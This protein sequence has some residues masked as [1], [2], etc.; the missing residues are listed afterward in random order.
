M[1]S[2]WS[3]KK[4]TVAISLLAVIF[5]LWMFVPGCECGR[6]TGDI[7]GTV[8]DALTGTAVAGATVSA[9]AAEGSGSATTADDGTYTIKDLE[10]SDNYTVKASKSGYVDKSVSGVKVKKGEVT[11]DVNFALSETPTEGAISGTV[12]G[13][14]GAAVSDVLVEASQGGTT[15]GSAT[16]GSDGKYTIDALEAGTYDVDATPS[17]LGL[18]AGHQSGVVVVA[19]QV[20]T[21][22]DF[23][24]GA[25]V[26]TIAGTVT[27]ASGAPVGGALVKASKAGTVV[28]SQTSGASGSYIISNL[29][30]GTYDV[31]AAKGEASSTQTGKVVQENQTTTVDFV[32]GGGFSGTVESDTGVPLAGA[33]VTAS[34]GG[35]VKGSA[36]VAT[37]GTYVILLLAAGSYD[38]DASMLGYYS[39]QQTGVAVTAGAITSN[40]DLTLEFGGHISGTVTDSGGTALAG[41]QVSAVGTAGSGSDST[42]AD[43]T[44]LI[45]GV[46]SG[47]YDVVAQ[48]TGY[49]TGQELGVVVVGGAATTDIDFALVRTG[50]ISGTVTETG[51]GS[52]VVGATVFATD[53][54]GDGLGSA[55]TGA[56][57]AYQI[58]G[59]APSTDYTVT[60]DAGAQGYATDSQSGVAVV[61]GADTPNVDFALQN[62][63]T[64]SGVVTESDGTTPIAGATVSADDKVG[65]GFGEATTAADGTYIILGLLPSVNYEVT[66]D[67]DNFMSATL[68]N[69]AVNVGADTPN[70]NFA[71]QELGSISG[72]VTDADTSAAVAG[73]DVTAMTGG[74]VM[75]T[76]VTETDGTYT[77]AGLTPSTNYNVSAVKDGYSPDA[78]SGVVVVADAT[79]TGI[80]FALSL[81]GSI[82][83]T[84]TELDGTTAIAGATVS[85]A[86]PG[87]AGRQVT[88][89]GTGNYSVDRL[90]ASANYSVRV[91]KT[92]YA[93][94]V[95]DGVTVVV[96]QDTD[97][98]VSL[99]PVAQTGSI[100]GKVTAADGVT[101]IAGATVTALRGG[102]SVSATT[103]ADG[104]YTIAGLAPATDYTV[105]ASA[106]GFYPDW[107]SNVGVTAGAVT[108]NINF[109]LNA[110]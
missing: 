52:A 16:T 4:W 17:T 107:Q 54:V 34:I 90:P 104:T 73:A 30:V 95:Q 92:G 35:V 66:A 61:G 80:D 46:G 87:M 51:T 36:T 58:F 71:L 31:E 50:S 86:A 103:A 98:D 56:G 62:A 84:V 85:I 43:G 7:S 79:T 9:T 41:V 22:V 25:I 15:K 75:G 69:I 81:G 21:G 91:E 64:I 33:E 60:V 68:T 5:M 42:A 99:T 38:V 2:S 100:S 102:V 32:L 63:G 10:P 89:D 70:V 82:S 39:G 72:T 55:T 110:V 101:G 14:G 28:G 67:A 57:G 74:V 18:Y 94:A 12:R 48:E 77:I 108:T 97:V 19:G 47:T 1:N 24:L 105:I 37:D 65:T 78:A 88:T 45:T 26:G 27:D 93:V 13:P 44:Y 8:T 3:K 76:A 59:L 29:P 40:I 49:I 20:T 96:A 11:K 23:E 109:S 53:N 6:S 106:T 83:G